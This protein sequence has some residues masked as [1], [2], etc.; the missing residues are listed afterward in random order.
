MSLMSFDDVETLKQVIGIPV[1][2]W[3]P[4]YR[5][6]PTRVEMIDGSERWVMCNHLYRKY[7]PHGRGHS[8]YYRY[9]LPKDHFILELKGVD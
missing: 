8:S 4:T 3:E 9:R 6:L 5:I 2:R 1:H 7:M